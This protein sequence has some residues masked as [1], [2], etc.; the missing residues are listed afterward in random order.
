[1][2]SFSTLLLLLSGLIVKGQFY[3][4][5]LEIYREYPDSARALLALEIDQSSGKAKGKALYFM[6]YMM[7]KEGDKEEALKCYYQAMKV[8]QS[9][10]DPEELSKCYTALANIHYRAGSYSKAKQYYL[11]AYGLKEDNL[12]RYNL[13]IVYQRFQQF[14]SSVYYLKECYNVAI[15]EKDISMLY[16]AINELGL[17]Y[18]YADH[19]DLAIEKHKDLLDLATSN[20]ESRYIGFALTNIGNALHDAEQYDES[21]KYLQQSLPYKNESRIL[22]S[23]LNLAECYKELGQNNEAISYFIKAKNSVYSD[24][25]HSDYLSTID[26]LMRLYAA[27]GEQD[28]AIYY[29]Q[30]LSEETLK[31]A[32]SRDD[33]DKVTAALEMQLIEDQIDDQYR[34]QAYTNNLRTAGIIAGALVL[35][36]VLGFTGYIRY[37]KKR[38]DG[39]IAD[40]LRRVNEI[41]RS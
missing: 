11:E 30:M 39:I 4:Q 7:N 5:A 31:T 9:E 19:F 2:K 6:G 24:Q 32:G 26:Q 10:N 15:N 23:Y 29:A 35:L 34:N 1:M 27:T 16:M 40:Q 41:L 18:Y 8:H 3:D 22:T 14:D 33:L 28:S 13:G 21:I 17:S 12:Y 20:K 37:Q 25:T 36:V 38:R